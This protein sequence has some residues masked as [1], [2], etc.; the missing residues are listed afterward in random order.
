VIAWGKITDPTATNTGR[1]FGVISAY[2][3]HNVEVGRVVADSTW[4]HWFD[5]NLKGHTGYPAPYTGFVA[6]PAGN[7]ALKKIDAYYLN[8]GVWLSPPAV[9]AAMRRAAWWAILWSDVVVE[10][11]QNAPIWYYGQVGIDALGRRASRCAVASWI[12]H[13]PIFRAHIPWWEWQQ[14]L[15][16]FQIVELPLE[17]Y[18]AGGILHELSHSIGI[19]AKGS[20]FPS[21]PPEPAALD[22]IINAGIEKGLTALTH[23]LK[24]EVS[25]LAPLIDGGFN[26]KA[27]Q[28]K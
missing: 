10:L 22:K 17:R 15:G 4:H 28:G 19:H 26:L 24:R 13:P 12:F 23:Q 3:G 14:F 1:E 8:V 2:D 18:V 11:P 7:E 27:T 16:R 5:I 21:R 6:T 9:Q 25:E 20:A